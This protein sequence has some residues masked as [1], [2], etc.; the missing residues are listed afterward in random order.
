MKTCVSFSRCSLMAGG[1]CLQV[2]GRPL[3][4]SPSRAPVGPNRSRLAASPSHQTLHI[5]E[6]NYILTSTARQRK[7]G[8]GVDVIGALGAASGRSSQVMP[9]HRGLQNG[10]GSWWERV[11]QYV[12]I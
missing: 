8:L 6:V 11:G 1:R 4:R 12:S 3:R 5:V 10:R 9:A 2:V 7:V